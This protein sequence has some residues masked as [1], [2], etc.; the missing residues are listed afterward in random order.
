M[1]GPQNVSR[2]V[3][4][5]HT[6]GTVPCPRHGLSSCP[7]CQQLLDRLSGLPSLA[8]ENNM[9]VGCRRAVASGLL[10]ALCPQLQA[11]RLGAWGHGP[12][13]R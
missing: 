7:V 3:L 10:Y 2:K 1:L 12:L 4:E 5:L 13:V 6:T 9:L 11:R 8:V